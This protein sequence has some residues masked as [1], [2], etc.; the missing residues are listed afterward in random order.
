MSSRRERKVVTVLFAD[1]VG[2]TS[3]A[4]SLDPEDVEA[5]LRPYHQR[6]RDE[7]ERH[8]G[9]VEKFIGDAVMALFGAPVAHEDDPERAVRAALAI[10]DWAE[11][12]G[13]L[14]VR[15]G[16]TTGE[17]LVMLDA[18]PEAG[19]GMASGDV[20]NTAARLQA[21]AQRNGA[22]V[23]ETSYRATEQAI[24]YREAEPVEAKG[25]AEPIG[26]WEPLE[27]RS[28]VGV[29]GF[30]TGAP[31]VGRRRELNVLLDAF[32]RARSEGEPQL[33]T[34]VGVPGIGKSR[35]VYEFFKQG[36]EAD[37]ELIYWRHG[38][39]LP[40]GDGVTYWAV[41]EM[42]KA[43]AGILETD[44]AVNAAVKLE[45]AIES[46][47]GEESRWVLPNVRPLV[48]L[49]EA[50]ELSQD[51]QTEAFAA[52]RRLFEG[53]AEEHP[54]VLAFED[55][56][57]ADE[58]LLDFIDHLVEWASGVPI[59][60]LCTARPELLDRRPNWGGGKLNATMLRVP[61][62]PDDDAARLLAALIGRTVLPTDVQAALVTRA[63]GN[64]LYA[65]Q[66]ARM[67]AERGSV[68][69]LPLPEN[70]QGLIAARL[71][72]LSPDE[73]GL[74]Q[75]AAVIGRTFWPEALREL[76]ADES[77]DQAL[78][79][80]ERKE[81]VRRERRSTFGNEAEYTFRHVL[82]RG[83]AYGQ[84]PRSERAEK[85]RRAAGW[86]DSL[87]RPE[88][89]AEMLAHHYVSAL[90]LTRAAGLEDG[91]LVKPARAALRDA[92]DR[93]A[94]LG[95]FVAAGRFYARALELS[96]EEREQAQLLFLWGRA[97][98]LAEGLGRRAPLEQALE[99]LRASDPRW[100]AE[101]ESILAELD[102]QAGHHDLALERHR[103]AR[104][105]VADA[106]PSRSKGSVLA[107]FARFLMTGADEEAVAVGRE[108]LAIAEALDA[109]D[110]ISF[111]LNVIGTTRASEGDEEGIAEI[112][113]ALN[114]AL[115]A[116]V[117]SEILRGYNNLAS[118]LANYG[119]VRRARELRTLGREAAERF[120]YLMRIH[121]FRGE[122]VFD[123]YLSG[124]WDEALRGADELSETQEMPYLQP[125]CLSVRGTIFVARGQVERGLED[126]R[127]ALELARKIKDPQVLFSALGY[128]SAA[129]GEAGHL[130]D[131]VATA[132]ELLRLWQGTRFLPGDWVSP[133]ATVLVADGRGDELL[134]A[135]ANAHG[136]T[137]WLDAIR[138]FSAGEF[139]EAANT[140]REIG[141]LPDEAHA[142]LY[143][144]LEAEV[145]R[146]L[147]FYRS[148]GATRY[149]RE[150]EAMLAATA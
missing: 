32:G 123:D 62:L 132:R 84:I 110:L 47:V 108:A 73:K 105:L 71:D 103:R 83:V 48:G 35:L 128:R 12:E 150:G 136:R 3:R 53:L 52:W 131:A 38:R 115:E 65:E 45:Q 106:P 101:A 146:A 78:H 119:D 97:A 87:G 135:A 46:A 27:A 76:G 31:L 134:E 117:P 57:W 15:I 85:H 79:A 50:V 26:V 140:Y 13:E 7:L 127:Q 91:G 107:S 68:E 139:V 28:R 149:V 34:L 70:V 95:A 55:L 121:W 43:Q 93:A 10:R 72:L 92:G 58:G 137:R 113:Q 17:A 25:K 33:V 112:E 75:D 133:L 102:F 100:A 24:D 74:L 14:E 64:P 63:G 99:V 4:E 120:G 9:T 104:A 147:D 16:I 129:L 98:Y 36:I 111:A 1:L 40:Y 138:A 23:D 122:G 126:T 60:V 88:D 59:L 124:R 11:E 39:C 41:A 51:H 80:L 81:F 90:E 143:S 37:P 82:V 6:L 22:L 56:H 49:G 145:R 130:D 89:H 8:G 109:P 29:E 21:A 42:V 77:I 125:L 69:D 116:N 141:S 148:V 2:F 96:P 19:E 114:L 94:S 142:R 67:L 30:E 54:L 5:I 61:A 20:V 66:Y 44:S 18:R 86:L 118:V 144:G